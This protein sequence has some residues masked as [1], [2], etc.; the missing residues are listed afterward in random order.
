M[1]VNVSDD[2][3]G[4]WRT[5]IVE[6]GADEVCDAAALVYVGGEGGAAEVEVAVLSAEIFV[7]LGGGGDE[8]GEKGAC[9]QRLKDGRGCGCRRER[10]AGRGLRG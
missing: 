4:T 2:G 1:K 10:R 6:D 9:A 5:V 3:R 7:R 8:R